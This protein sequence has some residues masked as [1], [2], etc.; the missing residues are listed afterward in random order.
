MR[1]NTTSPRRSRFA[2]ATRKRK[3]LGSFRYDSTAGSKTLLTTI[4]PAM[5][6]A[7]LIDIPRNKHG[8]ASGRERVWQYV[9]ITVDADSIKKKNNNNIKHTN[10]YHNIYDS[11]NSLIQ[12][13]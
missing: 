12:Y 3:A 8:R 1:R 4:T 5:Q 11:T 13:M 10:S 2:V 9:L 7:A 6:N